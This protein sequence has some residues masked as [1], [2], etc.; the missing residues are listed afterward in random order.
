MIIVENLTKTSGPKAA[1]DGISFAVAPG[2][3]TDFLGPA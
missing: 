3:V 1:V 2:K